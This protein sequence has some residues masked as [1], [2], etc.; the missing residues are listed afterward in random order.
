MQTALWILLFSLSSFSFPIYLFPY[1]F[2]KQCLM[3]ALF[4][5]KR[6]F[7]AYVKVRNKYCNMVL[8]EMQITSF[9]PFYSL[10]YGL[11]IPETQ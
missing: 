8:K 2:S 11:M 5:S 7:S 4:L 6:G 1:R 3:G 9:I 10:E